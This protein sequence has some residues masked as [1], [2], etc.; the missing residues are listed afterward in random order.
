MDPLPDAISE[1]RPPLNMRMDDLTTLEG[2]IERITFHN[3]ET[4]YMVARLRISG[5]ARAVTIVGHLPEPRPGETLRLKGVWKEHP[6]YGTQ[7]QVQ[8]FELLLPAG[9]DEIREYLSAGLIK[10]IGPKTA[11]RL[12]DHFQA[13]TLTIIETQPDR[14]AEVHGIGPDTATKIH[15]AWQQHHMVRALMQ[16]LQDNQVQAAHAARIFKLYGPEALEILKTDPYRWSPICRAMDF[17]S[18][19][20]LCADRIWPST[21]WIGL[22]PAC[23]ICWKKALRRGTCIVAR[24]ELIE[25]SSSAFDLDYHCVCDAI[26]MLQA[27][28]LLQVVDEAPGHTGLSETPPAGRERNRPA[29]QSQTVPWIIPHGNGR[30]QD[31][32]RCRQTSGHPTLRCPAGGA[33][34]RIVP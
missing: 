27:E 9:V 5:Q 14:M 33:Q 19:M 20:P 15:A 34:K 6:R 10:G 21:R 11:E 26:E 29:G 3:P 22:G 12:I 30:P 4:Q 8:F 25:R 7:F 13:D 16:F 2:R 1:R 28:D 32:G 24:D 18:P 23:A 17:I 31:H